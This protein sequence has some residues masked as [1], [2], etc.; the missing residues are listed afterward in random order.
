MGRLVLYHRGQVREAPRKIMPSADVRP[1]QPAMGALV[2]RWL[3][4]R[5]AALRPSTVNHLALTARSFLGHL[6]AAAP[7]IQ[8]FAAV[9]H[10]H[11]IGWMNAMA[12]ELSAK[13]G[14]PL[15]AHSQR[16]RVVRLRNSS[17]TPRIGRGRTWRDGLLSR[18]ASCLVS[19]TAFRAIS[20]V[21]ISTGS[22][23][24]S[25]R[26]LIRFSERR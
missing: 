3:E 7:E 16:G 15:T 6:A 25:G 20:R 14:R 4:R 13:T 26:F 23:M 1:A 9:K 8:T 5:A 17:R 2:E 18:S 10:R 21:P 22:W 12:T 24:R 19:L 11:V